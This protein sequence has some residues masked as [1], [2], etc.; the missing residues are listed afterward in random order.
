MAPVEIAKN[1]AERNYVSKT[2]ALLS[3]PTYDKFT[4][5]VSAYDVDITREDLARLQTGKGLR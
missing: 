1:I 4:N 2:L 5:I 3:P